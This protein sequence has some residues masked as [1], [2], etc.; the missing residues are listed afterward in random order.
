MLSV[1]RGL[2]DC[3]AT[4][5]TTVDAVRSV[6]GGGAALWTL[7]LG[8]DGEGTRDRTGSMSEQRLTLRRGKERRV[9]RSDDGIVP[10]TGKVPVRRPAILVPSEGRVLASPFHFLLIDNSW[11][12]V[13]SGCIGATKSWQPPS[14]YRYTRLVHKLQCALLFPMHLHVNFDRDKSCNNDAYCTVRHTIQHCKL[15]TLDVPAVLGGNC[16]KIIV[17]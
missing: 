5:P 13:V 7:P 4:Q 6:W 12:L 16:Q 10:E 2:C 14:V 9:V 1:W 15:T 3:D 17:Q 11:S 8:I